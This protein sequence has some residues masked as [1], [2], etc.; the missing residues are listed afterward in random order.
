M[1]GTVATLAVRGPGR[2]GRGQ[3]PPIIETD[4]FTQGRESLVCGFFRVDRPLEFG[5]CLPRY[6]P[7]RGFAEYAVDPPWGEE[8]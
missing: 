3:R 7:D 1:V 2:G 4:L 5:Q 6:D 8:L